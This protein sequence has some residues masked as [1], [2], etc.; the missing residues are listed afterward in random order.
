[1]PSAV[2]I[3][4]TVFFGVYGCLRS[5]SPFGALGSYGG[6]LRNRH[7]FDWYQ[8]SR[9]SITFSCGRSSIQ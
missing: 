7:R 1:M 2:V 6:L 9:A 8:F 5:Y 4:P 3:R